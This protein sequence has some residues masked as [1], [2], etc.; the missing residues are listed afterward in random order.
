MMQFSEFNLTA[1]MLAALEEMGLHT[2]T[3][4]QERAFSV[5]MSGKDVCGIAQTGTGK[6]LAYLLPTIRQIQFAKHRFPQM[7]ILVPTRELVTQVVSMA[8]K[9]CEK[10]NLVVVGAFGGVNMKPQAAAIMNGVDIVVATPGRLY[11]LILNGALGT[12]YI[13]RLVIDEVDEMMDL[14]FRPQLLRIMEAL[15]EKRQNLMFSATLSK[16]VEALLDEYFLNPVKVEAAPAGSPLS[17][18]NQIAYPVPNFNTKV[19]FVEHLLTTRPDM[20]KVL[21]FTASRR[22]ADK[23]YDALSV[24]FA[25]QIGVIHSNKEQSHRFRII[26]GLKDNTIR[27]VIATDLVARGI[28]IAGVTHVI[29]F[30]LPEVAEHYIHRIGR[31][32]RADQ[33]GE[34]ISLITPNDAPL[35]EAI[36]S[37]MQMQIPMEVFPDEDVLVST[38]LIPEEMPKLH[39]RELNMKLPKLDEN[40]GAAFHEKSAKNQK[41]N[42]KVSHK[43]KMMQ[44]YGKPKTR[45]AKNKKRR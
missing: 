22:F 24:D 7:L 2:P 38:V 17:N 8:E 44:K 43:D 32:G 18:I 35:Q 37:L 14:G 33:K 41:T 45:G 27:M 36:E 42:Q 6:T 23:L 39:H 12:K 3:T 19:N 21:L 13:K 4:I 9:L 31:T 34:A 30:D 40:R 20:S 1:P 5:I 15:P 26:Q 16:E 28:D 25:D 29:N 11:D 10:R